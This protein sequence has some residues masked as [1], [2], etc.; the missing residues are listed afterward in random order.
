MVLG[1]KLK[2]KDDQKGIVND[3]LR[4]KRVQIFQHEFR[5]PQTHL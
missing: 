1:P 5:T 4:K 2:Q 3:I